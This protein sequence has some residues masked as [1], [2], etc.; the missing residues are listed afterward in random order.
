MRFALEQMK[1]RIGRLTE[2]GFVTR[3]PYFWLTGRGGAVMEIRDVDRRDVQEK[4]I[5]VG[6]IVLSDP[7]SDML[8]A[9]M[10][11][12]RITAIEPDRNNPLLS[13]LTVHSE[14]DEASLRRVYVYDPDIGADT[15]PPP[16]P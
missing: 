1:V 13:I 16:T 4:H 6:D 5:Q 12:G 2:K 11:I 15:H 9:A 7:M 14:V 10:T 8:P 3:E